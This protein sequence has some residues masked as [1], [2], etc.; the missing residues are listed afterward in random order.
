MK[1]QLLSKVCKVLDAVVCSDKPLTLRELADKLD[2]P[3]ATV[4][5]ITSD[6]TEMALLEKIT[7][8]T[9]E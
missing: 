1:N 5:R 6:L 3:T 9:D 4:G 8:N 7:E 2:M